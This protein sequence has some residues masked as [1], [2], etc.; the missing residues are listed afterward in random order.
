MRLAVEGHGKDWLLLASV[1]L[2]WLSGGFSICLLE[3]DSLAAGFFGGC[4]LGLAFDVGG[5]GK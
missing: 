3:L 4:T 5:S 2:D 1:P